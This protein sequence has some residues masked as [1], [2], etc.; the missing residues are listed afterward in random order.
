MSVIGPLQVKKFL[1]NQINNDEFD[2]LEVDSVQ[3]SSVQK[4]P[5]GNGQ[6]KTN[7]E[8][9]LRNFF[10]TRIGTWVGSKSEFL[11]GLYRTFARLVLKFVIRILDFINYHFVSRILNR[12]TTRVKRGAVSELP[13]QLAKPLIKNLLSSFT[14][15][16]ECNPELFTEIDN[17]N[18]IASAIPF[19]I[20]NLF[21]FAICAC[22]K[23][24]RKW[25]GHFFHSNTETHS[26]GVI[27]SSINN[28]VIPA[29]ISNVPNK[30]LGGLFDDK[31]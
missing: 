14:T 23:L 15:V 31:N 5:A 9:Y 18:D 27:S 10:I 2:Y 21:K 17:I 20:K 16:K 26:T 1:P 22:M 8:G 4:K 28:N 25:F 29:P 12:G 13:F 3:K 6:F 11:A 19:V 24:I 7:F 30:F